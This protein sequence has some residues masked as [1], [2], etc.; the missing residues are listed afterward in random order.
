M[1]P[2]IIL[3]FPDQ[4][5]GDCLGCLGHPAARTPHLDEFAAEGALFTSA[6]SPCPTCIAARASLMTGLSPA[7]HG[8]LGYRDGV[9]WRYPTTLPGLLRDAGWQTICV[10]KTHFFPARIR[11]GFEEL[12]LYDNNLGLDPGFVDD[13]RRWLAEQSGG[14]VQDTAVAFSSNSWLV[15]PWT[16]DERLHSSAWVLERGLDRLERRDPTRPFFLA[17]NFHRPHPP[18]D[19]PLRLWQEW[20]DRPVPE[21]AVGDWCA[22]LDRPSASTDA[23]HGRLDPGRIRDARRAYYAQLEHIDEQLGRLRRF[24]ATRKLLSDTWIIFASDH[25]ELHGDHHRYRKTAPFDGSARVPLIIRPPDRERQARLPRG[26][27][28]RGVPCTLTDLLPTCCAIAGLPAP[29]ACEGIDLLPHLADAGRSPERPCVHIEHSPCWQALTDGRRK[30]VWQSD[31]GRTLFFDLERDPQELHDAAADPDR[32]AE[33]AQ[34]C[35]RL[36][37]VL[38]GRPQ[39]GL[40]DGVRL[41]PGRTTPA[42]RPALLAN[43]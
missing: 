16:H 7:T 4:W 37:Q 40:S 23:N 30:L 8:R 6:Y 28:R 11:L 27:G 34:W 1:A 19:P 33:V 5:R 26:G 42:V 32:A 39:D 14:Q 38:G 15:H 13:Y 3:V 31:S 25:G 35:A 29:A 18:L 2:N 22:D 21:P 10:G 36:A 43:A 9:P 12:D 41:I 20:R 24:L 17:L